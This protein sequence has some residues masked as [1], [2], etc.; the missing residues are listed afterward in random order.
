MSICDNCV[1]CFF[2]FFVF[3]IFL[4]ST[5]NLIFGF[6]N[7]IALFIKR[8]FA[9]VA[10]CN[11]MLK[12]TLFSPGFAIHQNR[13]A[14]CM[15]KACKQTCVRCHLQ[16]QVKVYRLASGTKPLPCLV[17]FFECEL[18]K[19]CLTMISIFQLAELGGRYKNGRGSPSAITNCAIQPFL[20]LFLKCQPGVTL[21]FL[22]SQNVYGNE[23]KTFAHASL[24]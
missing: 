1:G 5:F 16:C 7:K 14:T 20:H 23:G 2:F 6:V 3:F 18:K 13:L 9:S 10:Q 15:C 21:A 24:I 19:P 22:F 17:Q 4:F 8:L 12:F 11:S